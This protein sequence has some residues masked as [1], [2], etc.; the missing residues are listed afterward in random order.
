MGRISG[1]TGWLSVYTF[2]MGITSP[3]HNDSP[4]VSG[5]VS[6][7]GSREVKRNLGSIDFA[8][9]CSVGRSDFFGAA[10]VIG[11]EIARAS[12][13]CQPMT[14]TSRSVGFRVRPLQIPIRREMD[15]SYIR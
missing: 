9:G 10:Y 7:G 12:F 8:G 11:F 15:F 4:M 5:T 1:K 6:A 2:S 13:S 14:R 3:G